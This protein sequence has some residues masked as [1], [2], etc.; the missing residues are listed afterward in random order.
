MANETLTQAKRAKNDEFYTQYAD[1]EKEM[2]AYL[3]YDPDTFRNKVVLL[4]CDDPEWSN[5]TKYFAQNFDRLGIKKL[6]S[7][8]YSVS[9]KPTGVPYQPSLFETEDE[10]F[11]AQKTLNNG[12]IF[13]LSRNKSAKVNINDLKWKYLEGDGDFRSEEVK[14]LRD[15]ADI[16]IT[17]PPFSLFREFLA[18]LVESDARYA[19]IGNMNAITYKEVFPLIKNN[20]H[21]LG[22]TGNGSDMVF[23]V[24]EGSTIS[25]ADKKKA[26]RLGYEGNYTRLGNSCWFTCID[27]GKRHQPLPLMTMED[28][29]RFNKRLQ[30]IETSYQDYDNYDAIEVPVSSGI[31]SNYTGIM[32]VPIS[33]LDKYSP[34]QFEIVGMCEN[35]DLYDLKTKIYTLEEKKLAYFKKFN[36]KGSYDLNA[37]GVVVSKDG[38]LEKVYQRI[39]IK[40]RDM[41]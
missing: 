10:R 16:I 15:S 11:D 5:F 7:T 28:N 41:T 26:E 30:K 35:K 22:A 13:T 14:N 4:P 40:H 1:I 9:S 8:S 21:W 31:P 36:K 12:K 34:E 32:G 24:P 19:I 2:N 23:S 20:K 37:S 25:V 27:H 38:L 17:N 39:L 18:W 33:F 29:L 3:E 6:I